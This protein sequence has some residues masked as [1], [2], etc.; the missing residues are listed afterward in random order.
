MEITREKFSFPTRNYPY[1]AG[2]L[3][4]EAEAPA[5]EAGKVHRFVL[6]LDKRPRVMTD[7]EIAGLLRDPFAEMFL[8]RGVFPL[9]L[10]DLL[11]GLDA[12]TAGPSGLPD[13]KVFVIADGGQI[14]WNADTDELNRQL[15]FAIVRSKGNDA[16]LL[17]SS[18]S[19]FDRTDDAAF[20]QLI[21]W[22]DE[23]KVFNYYERRSGTWIWAGNSLHALAPESRGKGP[24][25]S[26]VNGSLVMKELRAPWHNWHSQAVSIR[27]TV[28]APDDPLRDDPVF[29]GRAGAEELELFV[30]AGIRRWNQARFGH[31]T[32]ADGVTLER[33]PYLMRQVLETT[34]VNLA[35]SQ[36]PSRQ[37]NP[38]AQLRLPTTFF[39]NLE[40]FEKEIGLELDLPVISVS[41]QFYRDSLQKH[42]F[43]L[44]DGDF[45]IKGDSFFAFLVPEPAFED[46]S[47]LSLL[48]EKRL[49]SARFAASLL[50][51]DFQNP[52]F[53]ERRKSLMRFVPETAALDN[54]A[55]TIS[56]IEARFVAAVQAGEAG[57]P[58]DGPEA[59]FLA[60]WRLPEDAWKAEFAARIAGY[61]E[62]LRETAR[63]E[64]GFDGWVRLAESRR[65]EF[66]GRRLFEFNLTTPTTNIPDTAPLLEMT[67]AG[68]AIKKTT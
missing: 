46:L 6:G 21:G 61:F 1:R 25:D 11:A 52:V 22:D 32:S 45:S 58:A 13:Q 31:F 43:S 15:R 33:V 3:A 67:A 48:L 17:V 55:G 30:R 20:L 39:I 26:H 59:E 51:V 68:E 35:T 64:N 14:P 62:K 42:A 54:A 36:Q 41:G 66:R 4:D 34:T 49:I 18:S 56:D 16:R 37:I 29:K 10:R 8:R 65:R 28:L 40:A 50:M 27:D 57:F 60:N 9:S 19:V 12:L 63:T 2:I 23:N 38:A 5:L 47:V 7:D 44:T 53:S 24:F